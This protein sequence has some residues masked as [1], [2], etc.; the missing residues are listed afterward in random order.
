VPG[1]ELL[2]AVA[3][4]RVHVGAIVATRPPGSGVRTLA[5]ASGYYASFVKN[6]GYSTSQDVI[7]R[8]KTSVAS[9]E[10]EGSVA[11]VVAS[12]PH[13]GE[14][15][16][17]WAFQ[18]LACP[19]AELTNIDWHTPALYDFLPSLGV[20][21]VEATLSKYVA[22]PNRDP[23]VP[24]GDY[25]KAAVAS[26]NPWGTKIYTRD[27]TPSEL[28]ARIAVAHAP[29]HL[30]LDAA[31]Q[32]LSETNGGMT[33]LI[34]LHSFGMPLDADVI[35]GNV[36]GTTALDRTV[37]RMSDAFTRQGFKVKVNEQWVGGYIVRRFAD[38]DQIEA[39]QIEIH[40]DTYLTT[41]VSTPQARPNVDVG[42]FN[43]ARARLRQAIK[44]IVSWRKSSQG[45]GS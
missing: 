12:L 25:W 1:T 23:A 3:F 44:E 27:P 33:L 15:M 37:E 19:V 41:D 26:E 29:F 10:P 43:D 5:H 21:T 24:Y 6:L 20:T 34:D 13:G 39:V 9:R 22:D 32:R 42:R 45:S 31:L 28:A 17:A 18:D 8:E 35:L 7:A 2:Q 30:A 11:P 4:G 38:N 40:Y 14:L 36:N 16:P